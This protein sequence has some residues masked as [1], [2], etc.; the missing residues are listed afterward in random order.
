MAFLTE[1]SP[2][3]LPPPDLKSRRLS[4]SAM[5]RKSAGL[6]S[7]S[8]GSSRH[9]PEWSMFGEMEEDRGA[10]KRARKA[11]DDLRDE[12]V[13]AERR[14]EVPEQEASHDAILAARRAV[15][16]ALRTAR[17][18]A[19]VQY[20]PGAAES[21]LGAQRAAD[22]AVAE[23]TAGFNADAAA[24]GLAQAARKSAHMSERQQKAVQ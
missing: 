5:R 11:I 4:A 15:E 1:D 22:D 10:M 19:A 8:G 2:M 12:V 7:P 20:L 24:A 13:E 18:A 3:L 14:D 17:A 21:G 6:P 9:S 23:H 16:N